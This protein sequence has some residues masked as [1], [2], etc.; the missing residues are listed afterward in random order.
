VDIVASRYREP[1]VKVPIALPEGLYEWLREVAF[2]RR[3]SMA[4]LVR[5]ALRDYRDQIDPQLDL[6]MGRE[7]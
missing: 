6:P 2:R 3:T 7:S 5:E 1:L 4:A